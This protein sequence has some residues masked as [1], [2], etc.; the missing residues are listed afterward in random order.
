MTILIKPQATLMDDTKGRYA[1]VRDYLPRQ[2]L[3]TSDQM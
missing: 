2:S 3:H 1:C